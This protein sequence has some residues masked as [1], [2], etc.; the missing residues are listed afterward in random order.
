MQVAQV[1]LYGPTVLR[2]PST[3][4]ASQ[5]TGCIPVFQVLF[6]ISII[7]GVEKLKYCVTSSRPY[8]VQQNLQATT[9]V[10]VCNGPTVEAAHNLPEPLEN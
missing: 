8:C 9:R 10:C 6:L 7:S 2:V 5:Y 4:L 1:N 3:T